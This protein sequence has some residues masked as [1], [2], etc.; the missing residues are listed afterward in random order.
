[1][2]NAQQPD[3]CTEGLKGRQQLLCSIYLEEGTAGL[4]GT[5]EVVSVSAAE[6]VTA[7]GCPNLLAVGTAESQPT[8]Q[9]QLHVD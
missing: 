1:M 9:S 7:D 3:G 5:F 2:R 4:Q 8:P 6:A